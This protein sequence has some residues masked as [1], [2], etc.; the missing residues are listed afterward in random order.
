MTGT[1][2][3]ERHGAL[4]LCAG[5]GDPS[6]KNL[7]ALGDVLS[8]RGNILVAK[9]LGLAAERA[10]FLS[11][12]EAALLPSEAA[13]ATFTILLE[14]HCILLSGKNRPFTVCLTLFLH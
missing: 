10:D 12:A 14:C 4:M 1:L 5:T 6:R 13:L 9:L 2:D 7:A 11:P 3:S 8:E